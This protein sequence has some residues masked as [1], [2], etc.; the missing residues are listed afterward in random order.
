MPTTAGWAHS[1]GRA[2]NPKQYGVAA[3]DV[4]QAADVRQGHRAVSATPVHAGRTIHLQKEF[5]PGK[6]EDFATATIP[7]EGAAPYAVAT[8]KLPRQVTLD[9]IRIVNLL[10]VFEV[11]VY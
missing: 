1:T 2:P 8:L 7:T 5:A 3:I 9:K 4:G 11:E 10:D 6:W